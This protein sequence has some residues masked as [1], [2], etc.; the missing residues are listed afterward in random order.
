MFLF[1]L[2]FIFSLVTL[3][4]FYIGLKSVMHTVFRNPKVKS[5]SKS[6][7]YGISFLGVGAV[8]AVMLGSWIG[9]NNTF[10]PSL[11]ALRVPVKEQLKKDYPQYELSGYSIH[12]QEDGLE[13][14]QSLVVVRTRQNKDIKYIVTFSLDTKEII[15]LEEKK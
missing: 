2:A 15:S 13:P 8:M 5:D 4:F 12:S 3:L 9:F 1:I 10:G 14:N 6:F 11:F 7:L